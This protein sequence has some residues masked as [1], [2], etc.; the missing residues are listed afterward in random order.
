MSLFVWPATS[1]EGT[2]METIP[3]HI[4][5]YFVV[6]VVSNHT[7]TALTHGL[8]TIARHSFSVTHF[9]VQD[10][11]YKAPGD[12]VNLSCQVDTHFDSCTWTHLQK[13]MSQRTKWQCTRIPCFLGLS[14]IFIEFGISVQCSWS[15]K[16]K[17]SSISNFPLQEH[18]TEVPNSMKM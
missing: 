2:T 18:W 16:F 1:A 7:T 11:L 4:V 5:L 12:T 13:V 3:S 9:P 15:G 17:H 10:P 14:Y 6:W 8:A